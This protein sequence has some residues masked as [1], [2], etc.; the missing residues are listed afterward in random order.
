MAP[1]IQTPAK[2][3]A[4][5]GAKADTDEESPQL[6]PARSKDAPRG[7]SKR[8]QAYQEFI[9]ALNNPQRPLKRGMAVSL[10]NPTTGRRVVYD[11]CRDSDGT[12]IEA[13]GPGY[14]KLL[15]YKYFYEK[16][17]PARWTNQAT[18]QILASGG[19]NLDW[20]CAESEGANRARE[21]FH[22]TPSLKRINVLHVPAVIND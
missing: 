12:M 19:R 11:D 21:L 9:S 14:A 10:I 2:T 20:F 3:D 5:T 18:R 4:T 1:Q 15:R 22:D 8:A 17:L 16:V 7:A 13:K 6:C